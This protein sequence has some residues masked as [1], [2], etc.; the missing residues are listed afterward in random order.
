MAFITVYYCLNKM[1]LFITV[2]VNSRD[3]DMVC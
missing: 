1:I 2:L 3:K